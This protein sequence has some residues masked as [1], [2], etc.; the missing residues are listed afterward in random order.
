MQ[1]IKQ[2]SELSGVSVRMLHY[3]DKIGLLKPSTIADNGYRLYDTASLEILQQILFFKELDVPL[4]NIK[5]ILESPQYDKVQALHQQKKLLS[6]KRDRLNELISLI[7]KKLK[8]GNTMSF[9]EFDMNDYFNTLETFKQEHED[10]IV[11]YY[12]SI[13][14]FEKNL[15]HMKT[16]ELKIARMAIE[17]F[18][19]IEK[20]TETIKKN[21][22]NLPSIMEGVQTIKD[23]ADT[24]MAQMNQ[25]TD[26]LTSDLKRNPSSAE[27]QE[28]VKKMDDIVKEQHEI[29]KMD[30]GTNYWGL[31]ANLY[32]TNPEYI[33]INDKK[34][35][36]GASKFM[37]E[38]LKFYGE[39]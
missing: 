3:Y 1:T 8:G 30:P 14:E 27:I 16:N 5:D 23:N 9:K 6:L 11:N 15:E 26:C 34:Y 37:G 18:G 12:G 7:D 24:Y 21:L 2:V 29:L 25:L 4:K 22:N 19:S 32:L 20:Y 36:K 31:M 33:K 39:K 17:Q 13:D 28:I 35:G 38:A 10:E